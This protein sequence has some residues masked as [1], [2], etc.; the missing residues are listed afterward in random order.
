[1]TLHKSIFPTHIVSHADYFSLFPE[2][3]K[4]YF[5]Y[6]KPRPDRPEYRIILSGFIKWDDEDAGIWAGPFP[7]NYCFMILYKYRSPLL[8]NMST[9]HINRIRNNEKYKVEDKIPYENYIASKEKPYRIYLMGNDDVSYSK[10]F[11]TKTHAFRSINLLC[12]TPT[13]DNLLKI[14]KFVFTN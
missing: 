12:H 4:H 13:N 1:M 8:P 9:L 10:V 2:Q 6:T 11:G 7:G 5:Q 3:R 14:Q